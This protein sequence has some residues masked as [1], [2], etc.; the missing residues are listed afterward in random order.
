MLDFC[1]RHHLFLLIPINLFIFGLCYMFI[2]Q[3]KNTYYHYTI[4]YD[5][6]LYAEFFS[7]SQR[8]RV[9]SDYLRF[10]VA[11]KTYFISGDFNYIRE[12]CSGQ[13]PD[14]EFILLPS[15]STP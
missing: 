12:E 14:E 2:H 1:E 10:H 13:M 4:Y 11:G 9:D 3:M 6:S 8:V 15:L 7:S 5:D